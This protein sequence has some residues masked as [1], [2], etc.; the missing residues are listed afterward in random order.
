MLKYIFAISMF[1]VF[2][3]LSCFAQTLFQY[4]ITHRFVATHFRVNDS[5]AAAKDYPR[6]LELSLNKAFNKNFLVTLPIRTGFSKGSED[7]I[8]RT[9]LATD[10]VFVSEFPYKRILP[11]IG[12]GISN[13]YLNK[14]WNQGIPISTGVNI[15]LD[16]MLFLNFQT[17]IRIPISGKNKIFQ[18]HYAIGLNIRF[19]K[20]ETAPKN[21]PLLPEILDYPSKDSLIVASPESFSQDTVPGFYIAPS[22]KPIEVANNI[23][24]DSVAPDNIISKSQNKQPFSP[25]DTTLATT[26]DDSLKNYSQNDNP[27]KIVSVYFNFD[28]SIINSD[29]FA[30]LDSLAFN[31]KTH[32]NKKA[33]ITGFTDDIGTPSY[34]SKL[35]KRRA[36]SCYNYLIKQ[37]VTPSQL[38]IKSMPSPPYMKPHERKL[39]RKTN[40]IIK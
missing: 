3:T 16:E 15:Q 5:S 31:L 27:S 12:I 24:K 30:T 25:A 14:K 1:I 21:N 18:Q 35:S 20:K 33:E 19:R 28:K 36:L 23:K 26:L 37:G 9:Y 7:T 17:G 22:E 40:I 38:Y 39:H 34:N 32:T 8:S 10:L 4:G 6:G 2:S 13:Q 29:Y 11:Y